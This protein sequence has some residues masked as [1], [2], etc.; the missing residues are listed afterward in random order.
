[1]AKINYSTQEDLL[2][3]TEFLKII[4]SQFLDDFSVEAHFT[5]FTILLLISLFNFENLKEKLYT[6]LE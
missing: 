3:K 6:F 5:H 4:V 1:L 2:F